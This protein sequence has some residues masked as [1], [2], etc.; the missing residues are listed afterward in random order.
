VDASFSPGRDV[1]G[2]RQ[3][4]TTGE[5]LRKN[6]VVR[7]FTRANNGI[8]AGTDPELDPTYSENDSEM[9]KEAEERKLHRMAKVH[10]FLE[11]WLGSKTLRATQ[12]ESRAH[13]EQMTAV[14][15]ISDTEEIVKLCWSLFHHEAA[16][17]FKLPER[18]R[19]P[20]A[21][22]A[23]DLPGGTT[24]SVNDHRIQRI[25]CH[26]VKSY[27]DS[28]PQSIP[29]TDDWLKWNG[30]LDNP[31]DSEEDCAADDESDT[32]P[33]TGIEDPA[34]PKQQDVSAAPNVPGFVRPTRQS[35]RQA[36]KVLVTI[37]GV[38]TRRNKGG[39]KM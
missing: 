19:L 39:K 27:E 2:W 6:V 16:A 11:M 20:P 29:D 8:L 4:K 1:I 10:D 22:S 21:L 38:E 13:N 31:N 14:G 28:A 15:Y 18:S 32:E 25:H 7:Q 36:E 5:T 33:N 26:P 37:N 23:N 30:D 35:K 12:K 17:A 3:S 24:P 34:C 9:K